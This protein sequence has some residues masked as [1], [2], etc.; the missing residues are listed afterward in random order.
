MHLP[1][2]EQLGTTKTDLEL[3]WTASCHEGSSGSRHGVSLGQESTCA[4]LAA[5]LDARHGRVVI[6]GLQAVRYDKDPL[7]FRGLLPIHHR[8]FQRSI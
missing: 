1:T 5:H 2:C 6:S 7:G 8:T 3:Q 4:R